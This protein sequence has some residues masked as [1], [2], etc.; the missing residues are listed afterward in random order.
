MEIPDSL[1][2]EADG[3]VVKLMT[4]WITNESQVVVLVLYGIDIHFNISRYE[5]VNTVLIGHR[6]VHQVQ[7]IY[8]SVQVRGMKYQFHCVEDIGRPTVAHSV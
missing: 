8:Y 7:A 3:F 5:T 4:G 1:E 6:Y 2:L